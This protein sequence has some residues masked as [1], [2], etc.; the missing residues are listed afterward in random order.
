MFARALSSV[1][2]QRPLAAF[3]Y[4]CWNQSQMLSVNL[5]PEYTKVWL[6]LACLAC[7]FLP[8]ARGGAG[9][10]M[11]TPISASFSLARVL[12]SSETAGLWTVAFSPAATRSG[13]FSM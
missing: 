13:F 6:L 11:S 3:A 2:L 1:T 5:P 10:L 8:V 4:I 9:L 12:A 7:D